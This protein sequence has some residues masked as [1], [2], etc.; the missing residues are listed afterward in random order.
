MSGDQCARP[1]APPRLGTPLSPE[2][3]WRTDVSHVAQHMRGRHPRTTCD[4]AVA[5]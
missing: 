1:T 2:L 5:P 3:D 4:A